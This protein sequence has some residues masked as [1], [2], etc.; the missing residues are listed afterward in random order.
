LVDTNIV[1]YAYDARDPEKLARARAVLGA[2]VA[3]DRGALSTQVLGEF[4]STLVRK[5]I[6]SKSQ[7]EQAVLEYVHSWIAFDVK[8]PSVVEAV[9]AAR[10]YQFDYYDALIWATAKLNGV[11]NILSE[12]GQDGQVL[13]GVRRM[14]PLHPSFD[15]AMLS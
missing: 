11:P 9:R 7:A 4:Y 12:D 3:S 15:L 8:L 2:L 10:Q 5:E 13:E 6:A 1:V 14:N